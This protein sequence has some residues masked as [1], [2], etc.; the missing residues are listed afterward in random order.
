MIPKLNPRD[1]SNILKKGGTAIY[2]TEGIYGLGC[3]PFNSES[4]ENIFK[5]KGRSKNK[6]FIILGSDIKYFDNII[7]NTYLMDESLQSINFTT[8]IVPCNKSCPPWLKKD[9][10]VA[11][12]LT[13]HE[14]V[15]LLCEYMNTPIISTSANLSN[16]KYDDDLKNIEK[17]F[18]KKIDCIVTGQLGNERKPSTIKNIITK[19]VIR[20]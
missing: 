13:R 4:V 9:N 6:S 20:A 11:I 15:M 5:A 17:V 19:E 10:T 7:D 12:R 1:A 2:P 8:W 14:T 18:E 16:S 3:D